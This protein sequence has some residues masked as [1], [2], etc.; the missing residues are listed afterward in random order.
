MSK[1]KQ[2]TKYHPITRQKPFVLLLMEDGFPEV[3]VNSGVAVEVIDLEFLSNLK[4]DHCFLTL[5]DRAIE[6]LKRHHPSVWGKAE[7]YVVS[8]A[9]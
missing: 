6:W 5:N 4:K 8:E 3:K 1:K 2:I 9:A 7:P